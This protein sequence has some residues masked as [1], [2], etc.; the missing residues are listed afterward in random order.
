MKIKTLN[1]EEK[2]KVLRDDDDKY[3]E[4]DNLF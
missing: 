4:H 3:N 1:N 2:E